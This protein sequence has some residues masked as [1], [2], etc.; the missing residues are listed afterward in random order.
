LQSANHGYPVKKCWICDPK[1]HASQRTCV[2]CKKKGHGSNASCYCENYPDTND[3]PTSTTTPTPYPPAAG[4]LLQTKKV[5]VLKFNENVWAAPKALMLKR[6]NEE[7]IPK[8]LADNDLRNQI[9]KRLKFATYSGC[10]QSIVCNKTLL[11]D[12]SNCHVQM[13]TAN[14]GTMNCPLIDTLKM[15]NL[16]LM[17]CL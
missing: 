13:S 5:P 6:S 17:N 10:T 8:N 14:S 11:S 3:H 4:L 1:K 7:S 2:D 16:S 9:D 12:Y 15:G